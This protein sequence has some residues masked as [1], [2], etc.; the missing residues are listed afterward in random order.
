MD[1]RMT[2][3]Q[4]RLAKA[5]FKKD[6]QGVIR[7]PQA[8]PPREFTADTWKVWFLD[9]LNQK[10]NRN[11]PRRGRKDCPDWRSTAKYTAR[12][13]NTSRLIIDYLPPDFKAR[14]AHRLRCNRGEGF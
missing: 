3:S 2:V 8:W 11:E 5:Y 9:R 10:I 13:V 14:F 1:I 7:I 12:Q 4:L 6:P